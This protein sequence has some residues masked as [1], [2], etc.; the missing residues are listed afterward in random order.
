MNGYSIT[1]SWWGLGNTWNIIYDE[2]PLMDF[3]YRYRKVA[4]FTLPA[5]FCVPYFPLEASPNITHSTVLKAIE[6]AAEDHELIDL[7][8]KVTVRS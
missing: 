1:T 5:T 3:F 4:T 2:G 6:H 8:G 7:V